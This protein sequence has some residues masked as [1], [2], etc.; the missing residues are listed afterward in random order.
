MKQYLL[1]LP[2]HLWESLLAVC[3]G[4]WGKIA[5]FIRDAIQEKIIRESEKQS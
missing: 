5:Q 1:R 2:V 3:N 4:E